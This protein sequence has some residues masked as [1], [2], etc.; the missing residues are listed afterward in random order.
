MRLVEDD[1][2]IGAVLSESDERDGPDN[3]QAEAVWG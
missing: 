2:A 3:G 1:A